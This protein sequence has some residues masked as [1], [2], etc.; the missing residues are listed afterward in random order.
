M[1][2]LVLEVSGMTCNACAAHVKAALEQVPGVREADVSYPAGFARIAVEPGTNID[3]VTAPPS[4]TAR[5]RPKPDRRPESPAGWTKRCAGWMG[6]RRPAKGR[7]RCAS[8]LSE[9]AGP[10]SRRPS[11]PPNRGRR[12]R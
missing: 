4:A 9:A 2:K 8:P 10:P 5:H 1:E 12:S 7:H 3:A 6:A 11:R